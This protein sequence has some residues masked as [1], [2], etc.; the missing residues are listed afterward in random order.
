[1]VEYECD[2]LCAKAGALSDLV[3]DVGLGDE[4]RELSCFLAELMVCLVYG[5]VAQDGAWTAVFA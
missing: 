3:V 5:I 2:S 4:R 1:M